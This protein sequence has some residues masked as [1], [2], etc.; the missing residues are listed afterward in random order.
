ML[1]RYCVSS[2]PLA[3]IGLVKPMPLRDLAIGHRLELGQHRPARAPAELLECDGRARGQHP[4]L[5]LTEVG[6]LPDEARRLL[7]LDEHEVEGNLEVR[8]GSASDA[9]S[10][11][12]GAHPSR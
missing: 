11:R 12:R 6:V 8:R 10:D 1:P 9:S 2:S 7:D 5:P 4:T 3:S